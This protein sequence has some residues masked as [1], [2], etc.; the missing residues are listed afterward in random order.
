MRNHDPLP[1][2]LQE[3]A[4]IAGLDAGRNGKP[5]H[6]TTPTTPSTPVVGELPIAAPFPIAA[7]PPATR[8][9]VE[10][11]VRAIGCPPDLIAIPML[12]TLSAGIGAS[13]VV[14]LNRKWLECAALFLLVVAKPGSNKT[15]AQK[16]ATEPVLDKQLKLLIS[17]QTSKLRSPAVLCNRG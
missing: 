13:R 9:S 4:N 3:R 10:E 5:N 17:T 6:E 16:V 7:L 1:Q 8:Q 15:P 2:D 11:A 12:G 14:R